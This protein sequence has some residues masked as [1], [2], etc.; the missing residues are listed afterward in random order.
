MTLGQRYAA[1]SQLHEHPQLIAVAATRRGRALVW[2]T[3]T[4]LLL[5]NSM[6]YSISPL[7]A[8]VLMAPHWRAQ[9]L[10]VGSV[11]VL[12]RLLTRSGAADPAE[13]AWLYAFAIAL[14]YLCYLAARSYARFPRL[15]QRN[16]QIVLHVLV[17]AALAAT[18]LV[19]EAWQSGAVATAIFG[20]RLLLPYL[21]WR[22]GYILLS[23]RRGTAVRSSFFDHLFYS[24]PVFGGTTAPYGKGHDHLLRHR[25]VEPEALA[26][27]QLAG[28]K[29]LMLVWLWVA[30]AEGLNLVVFGDEVRRG[31]M[32]FVFGGLDLPRLGEAMASPGGT[33]LLTR[34][35]SI[36]LEL[37]EMT[38][39]LAASGHTVIGCLRLFGFNVF[40]NT[41]KPLL[42]QSIVDFWNRYYYYFKEL[43]VEFFFFPTYVSAF[44]SYPRLRIFAAVMVSACLGNVYFH[45]LRDVELLVNGGL[46]AAWAQVIT[47]SF[48]AF[49]L[50]LGIFVSMLREQGRR[51]ARATAEK[52]PSAMHALR[53]IAGVWLFYGIIRIWVANPTEL[54]FTQRTAF[55]LSLFG[56]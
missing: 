40:R 20:V 22:M 30:S 1:L 2:F 54:T 6:V 8:L 32:V 4:L 41:Y 18:W 37:I 3:A 33:P 46:A 9:I 55:F 31:G 25:A 12:H 44:K 23:G 43:L 45:S 36:F 7:L 15:L 5:P 48:Y 27:S 34:W 42:A 52:A 56:F 29:L 24:F 11:W 21:V 19:P 50:A 17:V 47:R 28:I 14:L 49:L 10:S 16:A 35:L 39:Q 13:L 26:R 38:L 53:R 51:G